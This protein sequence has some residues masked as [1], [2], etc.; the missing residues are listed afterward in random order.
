M[1]KRRGGTQGFSLIEILVG[2]VVAT[3]VLCGAGDFF[4]IHVGIYRGQR[5]RLAVEENVRMA[6][7]F[8]VRLMKDGTVLPPVAITGAG[9]NGVVTFPYAESFGVS[10]GGNMASTLNDAVADWTPD[11][12]QGY[13]VVIANGTGMGQTRTILSNTATQAVLGANWTTIPDAT[14]LYK[15][16]SY[17]QF[18]GDG[19][20]LWYQNISA[21]SPVQAVGDHVTCFSVQQDPTYGTQYNITLTGQTTGLEPDTGKTGTTTLQSS[22]ALRN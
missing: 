20:T 3:L 12:W 16:L 7:D 5:E 10:T 9:C 17:R 1:R 11:Q 13:T 18:S 8:V 4:M 15:I 2:I 21:N 14:S 22:V 6:E 19:T